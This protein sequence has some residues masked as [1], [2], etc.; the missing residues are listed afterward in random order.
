MHVYRDI[1]NLPAFR[2]AILTIGTFDGVHR[3][4]S[5]IIHQLL[6]EA[7]KTGGTAV[8]ITFYPHPKQ[9][10]AGKEK[11]VFVLNTPEEKY[12]LLHKKGIEHIVVIPFDTAFAE[13]PA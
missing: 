8:V 4:H 5:Q 11:P 13:Q 9:V 1:N 6:E 12:E 2:N 3:G 7:K 10:I